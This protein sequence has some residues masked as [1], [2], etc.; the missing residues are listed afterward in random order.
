MSSSHPLP[1]PCQWF[2]RLVS[3]LDRRFAPQVR[4]LVLRRRP[5]PGPAYRHQ[6]ATEAEIQGVTERLLKLAA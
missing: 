1:T 5:G 3:A 2:A 6:A 4:P